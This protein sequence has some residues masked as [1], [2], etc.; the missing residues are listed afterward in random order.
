VNSQPV[1]HPIMSAT[2]QKLVHDPIDAHSP[3]DQ[4]QRSVI[5]IAE[6]EVIAVEAGQI[7]SADASRQRRHMVD[8]GLQHHRSHRALDAAV[9]KLEARVLVPDGFQIEV[10]AA[11]ERLEEGEGAGVC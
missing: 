2:K 9:S 6:D 1:D 8:V 11:E 7:I 4:L 5:C 10:R 3:A